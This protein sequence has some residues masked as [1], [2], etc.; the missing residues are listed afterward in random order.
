MDEQEEYVPQGGEIPDSDG[1][2][3]T[4][5]GTKTLSGIYERC[6]FVGAEPEYYVEAIKHDV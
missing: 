1:E 2:E 6:N 5:R 3:P 4:S